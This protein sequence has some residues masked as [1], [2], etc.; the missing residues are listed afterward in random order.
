MT[1]AMDRCIS[2]GQMRA[3]IPDN[4]GDGDDDD[5]DD[6]GDDIVCRK[7]CF[8]CARLSEDTLA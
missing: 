8:V 6:D 4:D 7:L 1:S 5:V 3:Q 2:F